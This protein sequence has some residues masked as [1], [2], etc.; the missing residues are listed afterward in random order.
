MIPVDTAGAVNKQDNV[1]QPGAKNAQQ[2]FNQIEGGRREIELP[3]ITEEKPGAT[4]TNETDEHGHFK[5]PE[6]YPLR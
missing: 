6:N 2:L 1:P 5:V 3:I 4:G